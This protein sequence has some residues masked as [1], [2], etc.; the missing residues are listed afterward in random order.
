MKKLRI[1][2]I[3]PAVIGVGIL[4]CKKEVLKEL[5]NNTDNSLNNHYRTYVTNKPIDGD[6]SLKYDML[7][8]T[9]MNVF[10]NT[11]NTLESEVKAWNTAFLNDHPGLVDFN[12]NGDMATATAKT[13]V[14]KIDVVTK[15]KSGWVQGYHYGAGGITYNSTLTW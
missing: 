1:L 7:S 10:K 14:H 9:D 2:F 12:P 5:E 15:T 13:V 11:M 3:A 6:I 4:S 8:F